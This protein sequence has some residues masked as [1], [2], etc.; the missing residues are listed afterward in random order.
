[1]AYTST[2][3]L[4]ATL[5]AIPDRVADSLHQAGAASA[6]QAVL[7]AESGE[8]AW[9]ANQVLGHLCDSARYWG[10]RMF[11]IAHEDNPLLPGIDQN[12]LMVAFAHRYRALDELLATFRL[13]SAGNIALLR[14]LSPEAWQRSGIHGNAQENQT[15]GSEVEPLHPR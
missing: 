7:P 13:A 5:A 3:D 4:I 10:A 11:R 12:A 6:A 15:N 2:V 14:D 1:M 8:G 9:N